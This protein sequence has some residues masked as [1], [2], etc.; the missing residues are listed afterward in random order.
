MSIDCSQ[1]LEIV[2]KGRQHN[3]NL[4]TVKDRYLLGAVFTPKEPGKS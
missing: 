2:L 1:S 3:W 4:K